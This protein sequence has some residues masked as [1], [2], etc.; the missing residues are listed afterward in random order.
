MVWSKIGAIMKTSLQEQIRKLTRA[1]RAKA[2]ALTLLRTAWVF[3]AAALLLIYLDV[4]FQFPDQARLILDGTVLLSLLLVFIFSFRYLTRAA[5]VEKM[6]ARLVEAHHPELENDLVNSLQFLEEMKQQLSGP[7]SKELMAQEITLTS[8][9]LQAVKGLEALRPPTLKTE[10]LLLAGLCSVALAAFIFLGPVASAVLPRFLDP[11]G[12]HP[13]YNPTTLALTP[14]GASV[15]YGDDLKVELRTDGPK[16]NAVALVL[17]GPNGRR[18]A[19]VPMFEGGEKQF[20]QTIENVRE[21]L[22]YHVE[23]PGGRSKKQ[24]LTVTKW[25][26]IETTM[27]TY[28][29]PAYTRLAPQT[30][31]LKEPLLKAYKGTKA[32]LTLMS[33]RPLKG[34]A[35]K[36]GDQ[37]FPFAVSSSNTVAVTIPLLAA[38]TFTGTIVDTEGNPSRDKFQGQIEIEPDLKPEIAIVSPG[39]DS[40]A[41]PDAKIPVNIEAKDDLGVS[42]VEFFQGFGGK[43][44]VKQKLA[45]EPGLFVN[46]IHELDLA[47][48][49]AQPGDTIE[50]YASALDSSPDAPQSTSTQ[51][52]KLAVISHEQYRELMQT[53]MTAEDL[54]HKYSEIMQQL[55]ELAAAQEKLQKQTAELEARVAKGEKSPELESQL[56]QLKEEQQK[57]AAKSRDLAEQLRQEAKTP[58]VFDIE[59]DFK[60]LLEQFAASLD[61]A[62]E[63]M[64]Q[65]AEQ[66]AQAPRPGGQNLKQAGQHQQN[67]LEKL[68]QAQGEFKESIQQA[69]DD[70]V[71]VA[72]LLEDV[73]RF[74]EL[75]SR[76]KSVETQARQFRQM[77]NPG[78]DDVLRLKELGEEQQ[79]IQQELDQ[80]AKDLG[81]HAREIE[82]DYP[83][84]AG[85]AR[86]IA[87]EIAEKNIP[88]L[89]KDASGRFA[90]ANGVQG[91]PPA[92][93][94]Y[95][96]M[97]SLVSQCN[98]S[99]NSAGS[100]CE[101]RLRISMN[102]KLGNTLQQMS[103]GFGQGQGS[104]MG[105]GM[106]MGRAGRGS[107]GESG[108]TPFG[109]FGPQGMKQPKSSR[110]GGRNHTKA[111]SIGGPPE[112]VATS[113]EEVS[114]G[115]KADLELTGAGGER[116]MQE[117]RKL[118]DAYFRKLAEEK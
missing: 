56:E 6:V 78:F 82:L 91:Y 103:R 20:F 23:I 100:Q 13:P 72:K 112:Q 16:P 2:R 52:F 36:L 47:E 104:G 84:V 93:E 105:M 73:E 81:Q 34:G 26:R 68:R 118:I 29:Y 3:L 50:Y 74:K 88:G 111:E 85:D 96:Q 14:A 19:S 90:S 8:A 41:T 95:E 65:G 40:F 27:V 45:V 21:D 58:D 11:Y 33:N 106:G 69:N 117:Y 37:E 5:S 101:L 109:L 24:K 70:I 55:E 32:T 17:A 61:G 57:L 43:D 75:L 35:L 66:M 30:R 62:G 4:A 60:K 76:Q 59:K 115:K 97:E 108:S 49:K 80:L 102:M 86:K 9:K 10:A 38:G 79:Q 44:L 87:Q 94:A 89:M 1:H 7:V 113:F 42:G 67:A 25:P 28:E 116:V 22:V 12:D 18:I 51:P 114:S 53:Q 39:M 46:A 98:S 64:T 48:L 92:L 31:L 110:G 77:Q 15:D 63:E 107:S 83:K 54:A 99:G 71:R